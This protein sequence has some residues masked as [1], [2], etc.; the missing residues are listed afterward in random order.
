MTSAR[1]GIT[2]H[3]HTALADGLRELFLQLEDR[4]LLSQPL[5]VYLAGG[6]AVHLYTAERVTTDVDAEFGAR[7]KIPEDLAV[8]IIL[9]DGS[10]QIVY[11]D[12]NYNSS[13]A[14]MHEDYLD[15]S[16]EVDMGVQNIE[17]R[18]LS[19]CDLAVSKIARLSDNDRE[20]IASLVRAGLTTAG[21][22]EQRANEAILGF[23]GGE[24]MLRANLRDALVLA[25]EAALSRE[26]PD[27][28]EP[29]GMD[30]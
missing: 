8:E 1:T 12:T 30:M 2:F 21:E 24:A 9:E 27:S 26:H 22:I 6:M 25:T 5:K 4:L 23:V 14:L 29:S 11:I 7:I 10:T 16:I 28:Y 13:F 3:T 18:V 19:P 20:D 17:L 15:D